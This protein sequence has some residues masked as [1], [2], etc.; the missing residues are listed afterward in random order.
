VPSLAGGPLTLLIIH[1]ELLARKD[2]FADG[3]AYKRELSPV[4]RQSSG[5]LVDV[6]QMIA[7]HYC[8][9]VHYSTYSKQPSGSRVLTV[10]PE[11]SCAFA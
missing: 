5:E 10:L 11:C 1:N 3:G 9:N 7:V 2:M 4:T 6:S 8:G